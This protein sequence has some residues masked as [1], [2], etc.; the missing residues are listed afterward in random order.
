LPSFAL[1]K[2]SAV[3]NNKLSEFLWL[4]RIQPAWT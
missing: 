1:S 2:G 3:S 4:R